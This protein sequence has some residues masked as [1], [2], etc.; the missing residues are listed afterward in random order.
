MEKI[1]I[2]E[3][4]LWEL[5]GENKTDTFVYLVIFLRFWSLRMFESTYIGPACVKKWSH[6]NL[7]NIESWIKCYIIFSIPLLLTWNWHEP[8][9]HCISLI[10]STHHVFIVGIVIGMQDFEILT[11]FEKKWLFRQMRFHK[12]YTWVKKYHS[13]FSFLLNNTMIS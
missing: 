4:L 3:K 9:V 10:L 1:A 2:S 6:A 7:L 5:V 12:I 11:F 13:R 8:K